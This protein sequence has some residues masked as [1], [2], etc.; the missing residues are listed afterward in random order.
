[1]G[2]GGRKEKEN[3]DLGSFG[4]DWLFLFRVCRGFG[5]LYILF[6]CLFFLQQAYRIRRFLPGGT[7]M[8]FVLLFLWRKLAR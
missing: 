4:I 1:M 3:I 7:S 2:G 8:V 5:F 6:F